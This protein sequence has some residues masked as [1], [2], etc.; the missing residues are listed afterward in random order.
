MSGL[1]ISIDNI[2]DFLIILRQGTSCAYMEPNLHPKPSTPSW[3]FQAGS[4]EPTNHFQSFL[5]N[6]M[7]DFHTVPIN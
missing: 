1:T 7:G 3:Q 5:Y 4:A 2:N 6:L